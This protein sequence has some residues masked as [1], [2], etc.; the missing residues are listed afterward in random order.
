M[1]KHKVIKVLP[2][3]KP[4]YNILSNWIYHSISSS[5]GSISSLGLLVIAVESSKRSGITEKKTS[6]NGLK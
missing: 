1:N 5:S 2:K 6:E 4:L 3:L